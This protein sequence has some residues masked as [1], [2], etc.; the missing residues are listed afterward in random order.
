[1]VLAPPPPSS[2]DA[3]DENFHWMDREEERQAFEEQVRA[4]MGISGPEFLRRLDSGFYNDSADAAEH[5]DVL[6]LS[7]LSSLAR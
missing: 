6:Y 1:M 5:S 4:I 7:M 2:A 3:T